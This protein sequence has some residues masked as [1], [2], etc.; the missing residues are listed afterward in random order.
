[1]DASKVNALMAEMDPEEIQ[2]IPR[3]VDV[4]L[5]VGWMDEGEADEWRRHCDAWKAFLDLDHRPPRTLIRTTHFA[6]ECRLAA[7][8]AKNPVAPASSRAFA[9]NPRSPEG[10]HD[11]I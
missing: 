9:Y 4:W 10:K 3:M 8:I 2:V 7:N 6:S 1:M 5:R 11:G